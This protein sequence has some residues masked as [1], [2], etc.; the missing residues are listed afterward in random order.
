MNL[1][2]MIRLVWMAK[3]IRRLCLRDKTTVFY[4][5]ARI[6]NALG[7][8]SAIRVGAFTHVRGELLTFGHGGKIEIGDY[9]YVGD[10]T[11]IWSG[12]CI[13]IGDRVAISHSCNIFDND[14]HPINPQ[15]R[16]EQFKQ[17]VSTGH[18]R[19]IDLKDEEVIIEDDVLISANA[20][21]LKGVRIGRGAIVG[22]GSVVTKDVAPYTIV[23][24]NPAKLIREIP[25]EER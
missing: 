4:R 23:A 9:C 1:A 5:S 8:L 10:H 7:D 14:T 12:K 11:R 19:V 24:G 2:R 15:K 25:F 16:H 18:P 6:V 13:K 22:A 17:L 20:I 3:S 21:V